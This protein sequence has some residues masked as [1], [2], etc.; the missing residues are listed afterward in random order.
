MIVYSGQ[1]YQRFAGMALTPFEGVIVWRSFGTGGETPTPT[2]TPT[3]T[4]T[5]VV[6]GSGGGASPIQDRYWR[7]VEK[8]YRKKKKQAEKKSE[9]AVELVERIAALETDVATAVEALQ[10]DLA[11][12]NIKQQALYVELLKLKLEMAQA[13]EEEEEAV[14]I[15]ALYS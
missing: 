5:S 10:V 9:R 2:P 8:R 6:L 13:D 3:P 1:R 4:D 7:E 15:A 14:M 12:E 11:E